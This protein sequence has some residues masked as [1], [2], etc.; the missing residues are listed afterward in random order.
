MASATPA[1]E[2]TTPQKIGTRYIGTCTL[3]GTGGTCLLKFGHAGLCVGH[4]VIC[5]KR[6]RGHRTAVGGGEAAG[7]AT[8]PKRAKRARVHKEQTAK[9][10]AA[11][12]R[13]AE[14]AEMMAEY[15]EMRAEDAAIQAADA[16]RAREQED[17]RIAQARIQAMQE[18]VDVKRAELKAEEEEMTR[19]V[20]D[21]I[22]TLIVDERSQWLA[23]V[24][25]LIDRLPNPLEYYRKL[26]SFLRK[27]QLAAAL[28]EKRVAYHKQNN[29]RPAGL[30]VLLE[31]SDVWPDADARKQYAPYPA[32]A[33]DPAEL[34][35]HLQ[36]FGDMTREEAFYKA[37]ADA[38]DLWMRS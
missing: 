1:S 37:K 32:G 34:V 12:D 36:E 16:K 30:S 10:Q 17:L 24:R 6:L 29:P 7:M 27:E 3:A 19:R 20:V 14:I 5:S 25:K 13:Q 26:E 15:E 23:R 21:E 22:D 38:R 4:G 9:E 35:Y 31:M 11:R 18:A 33:M 28:H 8:E 2:L